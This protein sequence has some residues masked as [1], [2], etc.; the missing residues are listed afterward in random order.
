MKIIE[1]RPSKK[2]KGAWEASECAGVA[3]TFAEWLEQL[4]AADGEAFWLVEE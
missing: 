2:F 1:V 3:P 4:V